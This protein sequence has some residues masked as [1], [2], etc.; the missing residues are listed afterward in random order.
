[1]TKVISLIPAKGKSIRIKN[2]NIRKYRGKPLISFTIKAS[3]KSKKVNKTFVSSENNYILKFAKSLNA[4]PIKK[5]IK[6]IFR[7]SDCR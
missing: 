2:K 5:R 4:I 7:K 1:M 3:I 6:I